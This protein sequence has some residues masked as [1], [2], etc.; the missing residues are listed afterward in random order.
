M[1][2]VKPVQPAKTS[3]TI[4]VTELGIVTEMRPEQ[5][6]KAASSILVTELGIVTEDRLEQKVNI[7]SIDNQR[8]TY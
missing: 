2:E 1:T 4:L 6:E 5:L 7:L 8:L 3:P